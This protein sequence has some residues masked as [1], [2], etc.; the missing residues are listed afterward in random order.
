MKGTVVRQIMTRKITAVAL[1][2]SVLFGCADLPAPSAPLRDFLAD[3]TIKTYSAAHGTQFAYLAADGTE[4]L[5][6]PG[7]TLPVLGAWDVR[8]RS[9]GRQSFCVQFGSDSYNPVTKRFGGQWEC[10]P[11]ENFLAVVDEIYDGDVLRL[12]GATELVQT[13]PRGQNISITEATNAVGFP[14]PAGP[15]KVQDQ[16]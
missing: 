4:T 16:K 2:C 10:R 6:Y 13:L 15:N 8:V 14:A 11:L 5:V 7:N 3:T 9:D 1:A 12:Y